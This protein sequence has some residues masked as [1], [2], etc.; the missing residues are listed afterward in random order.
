[1]NSLR[2]HLA[3]NSLSFIV[4]DCYRL[5]RRHGWFLRQVKTKVERM[6]WY[7]TEKHQ[8]PTNT[9]DSIFSVR[10]IKLRNSSDCPRAWCSGV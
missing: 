6:E 10:P 8:F 3:K 2:Q 1:M 5:D 7:Q 9:M 4:K